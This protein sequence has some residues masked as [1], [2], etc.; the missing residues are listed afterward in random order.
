MMY[1]TFHVHRPFRRLLT[2]TP[3]SRL[4]RHPG[5]LQE[6]VVLTSGC[7]ASTER[8][9]VAK[10]ISELSEGKERGRLDTGIWCVS[11]KAG[12]SGC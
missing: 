7:C 11:I 9:D 8:V 6:D 10:I 3:G 2:H 4:D 12:W 5:A 1:A